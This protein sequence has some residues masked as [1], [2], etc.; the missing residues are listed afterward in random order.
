MRS[1][2]DYLNLMLNTSQV[3]VKISI[4]NGMYLHL[5]HHIHAGG[6]VTN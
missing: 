6:I 1:E 3:E 2:V 4:F 5:H